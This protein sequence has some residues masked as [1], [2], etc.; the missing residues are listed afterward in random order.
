MNVLLVVG[1][2][3]LAITI[4]KIVFKL[5]T[6]SNN[7]YTCLLGKIAIV[8]GSNTGIGFYTAQDFAM[9]GA[10]VI[11]ACRN[12]DKAYN[13]K[14]EIIKNTGNQ[15]I[16]VEIV[17]FASLKSV[18]ELSQ[19]IKSKYKKIDILVNNAGVMLFEDITTEDGLTMSMQVN[20]FGPFLLTM[21]LIDLI[22]NSKSG[23]IV[24]LSSR[25][26]Y[27]SRLKPDDLNYIATSFA[28][29][30][31]YTNYANSKLCVMLW[32]NE[33]ASR[34]KGTGI[35][36]NSLHA[37]DSY[38]QLLRHTSSLMLLLYWLGSLLLLRTP[39][40]GAQT[41]IYGAVSKELE[42]VSGRYL[43][44]CGV[45]KTPKVARNKELGKRIWASA[46][47]FVKLTKEEQLI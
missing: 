26:V 3:T 39:T 44:N 15:N 1:A 16:I 18:R 28:S 34:L 17:D 13:A 35:I 8:T 14:E 19:R 32:T 11:L 21:L 33:L 24:N 30:F 42:N 31:F 46:E 22:Q 43:F 25:T 27:A 47:N 6:Y 12:V 9:R 37:G 36:V 20:F 29:R 38:T 40:E 2:I 7:S 4:I 45:C 10:T 41:I 5:T 23:R